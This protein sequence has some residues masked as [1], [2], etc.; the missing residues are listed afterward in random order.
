[1]L[2]VRELSLAVYFYCSLVADVVVFN[3]HFNMESFL[4]S[5]NSFLKLLPDYRPKGLDQL[6]RPKCRV[7]YFPLM[8][9]NQILEHSC[10]AVVF[11]LDDQRPTEKFK[12]EQVLD[13]TC[14][15]KVSDDVILMLFYLKL[16]LLYSGFV[17][18][19]AAPTLNACAY[20]V[21]PPTN[22]FH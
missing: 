3:S 15:E 20:R 14:S 9:S 16:H 13:G 5:I 1:M 6:I 10:T 2:Y 21:I 8:A 11:T 7:V 18:S 12:R 17:F 4:S 22:D 19:E